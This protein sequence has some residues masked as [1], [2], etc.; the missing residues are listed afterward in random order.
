MPTFHQPIT[1]PSLKPTSTFGVTP[2]SWQLVFGL[3][4]RIC[5]NHVSLAVEG[6]M[7]HTCSRVCNATAQP[8]ARGLLVLVHGCGAC[9]L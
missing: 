4:M 1:L 7:N 9:E 5:E 6:G 8:Y 3:G 2:D